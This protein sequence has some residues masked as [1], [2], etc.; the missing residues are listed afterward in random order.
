MEK[1]T[2]PERFEGRHDTTLSQWKHWLRTFEFFLSKSNATSDGDKLGLLINHISSEAYDHISDCT[3]YAAA[4]SML[5]DVYVKPVNKIFARHQLAIRK[6]KSSE[7]IDQFAQGLRILAKDCQFTAVTV[8]QRVNEAITDAFITGLSSSTIRQRLLENSTLTLE[9]AVQQAR[10][11]DLAQRNAELYSTPSLTAGIHSNKENGIESPVPGEFQEGEDTQV[12]AYTTGGARGK[13]CYFCG[14]PFHPRPSCP[15]R[16]AICRNCSRKGHYFRVCKSPRVPSANS[17]SVS[18]TSGNVGSMLASTAPELPPC[19][20]IST[21]INGHTVRAM[22]DSGSSYSFISERLAKR[23]KLKIL[24]SS[25]EISMASSS[26]TCRTRGHC[27]VTIQIKD[28]TTNYRM[29]KLLILEDLCA[30][31]I[32]GQDFMKL[33]ESVEF[34]TRGSHPKLSICSVAK[35][36]I[37][38]PSLFSNLSPDCR[39]IRT[40][41]RRLNSSD[42]KFVIQEV[43][44]LLKEDIIE[45]SHSPW[46]AQVLVTGGGQHKRRMVIDYSRTINKFTYLDAYPLPK[47]SDLI[48]DLASNKY[49]SKLDLKSA[50]HQV[51]LLENEKCYT[52]F[53]VNGSLY[54]FKRVPFGLTNAVAGFQRIVNDFISENG[55]LNTFAYIDDVIVGGKT[56][57][58]HDK[59]LEKFLSAASKYNISL[60]AEKCTYRQPNISYLGHT[61]SDGTIK[62]DAERLKPLKDMPIPLDERSLMRS[63]GLFSY[64]SQ[65]IPEYS[66]KISG[67][68]GVKVFPLNKRQ[69]ECFQL[70]KDDI[71]KASVFIFDETLP[72]DVETDAS[73]TAVAA[74]L[75]QS[76]RPIAFFSRTLSKVEKLLPA[77]EKEAAAIVEAVRHWKQYLMAR[78]FKITTD[79]QA[80][81]FMFNSRQSSRIKNDKILRWRLE[82]SPYQYEICFRPGKEN[83]SADALSRVCALIPRSLEKLR[84]LHSSLCHPGITRLAHFVKCKNLPYSLDDVSTVCQQCSIC[85]ELKPRFFRLPDQTLIHATRPFERIS[86]DFLGP[87]PS[88]SQNKYLLVMVDEYS[89]FPF[90]Y[91]CRDTTSKT[92]IECFEQLFCTFGCPA[93]VHSDRAQQ[94]LSKEVNDYML[95]NGVIITHSSPYHPKGNSQC[96]RLNG[97]IWKAVRLALRSQNLQ[98]SR[99]EAVLPSVLH[100]IRSLL[101]VST[102]STPHERLFH[103]PRKSCNGYSM[104]QWLSPPGSVLLKKYV[105]QNKSDSLVDRVDLLDSNPI[106]SR[107]RFPD[108]R[109][110]TVS[111]RDLANPGSNPEFKETPKPT[112]PTVPN[113][114]TNPSDPIQPDMNESQ[115]VENEYDFEGF[116]SPLIPARVETPTPPSRDEGSSVRRSTRIS[117]PPDRLTY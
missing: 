67:L 20:V 65:W 29:F 21:S 30:A 3:T 34:K 75:S 44:R 6:Q 93:S 99:W 89:R 33:H 98:E 106:V 54:Q 109:E 70:L 11:L 60:N 72:L 74:T 40:A 107:V 73:D 102:N 84:E 28:F 87:K 113:P 114:I 85:A 56:L 36:N 117:K 23:L 50:Y 79:Q 4:L 13:K 2:R 110:A 96:E 95:K 108:G 49:F 18:S 91:P 86:I 37:K 76:G 64:Y 25:E 78:P 52:A 12:S 31:V 105:R 27:F 7:S 32:L 77:I 59:N 45:K 53:E 80:V 24:A 51:P 39:P 115:C 1:F 14:G 55:L 61:I 97:T 111:T 68:L 66:R 103:H 90:V 5:R 43:Q 100:S 16:N 46:R 112:T 69:V 92:V 101:C 88:C 38:A 81:S 35:M 48:Q 19:S 47:I 17:R 83:L 82:L 63:V 116:E 26:M 42:Q 10:S 41:S 104:P 71:C 15:A 9:A 58:E 22:V 57:E 62:P 94:F 8:D